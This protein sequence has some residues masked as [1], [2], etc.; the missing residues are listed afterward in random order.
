MVIPPNEIIVVGLCSAC[1]SRENPSVKGWPIIDSGSRSFRVETIQ[2][3][4]ICMEFVDVPEGQKHLCIRLSHS[5]WVE[6]QRVPRSSSGHH[7]P[8][9]CI[10]SFTVEVIPWVDN[11]PLGLGHFLAFSVENKPEAQT[12]LVGR[13]VKHSCRHGEQCVEPTTGLVDAFANVVNRE[14]FIECFTAIKWVMPLSKWSA[15]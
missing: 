9:S 7:V 4:V 1:Q 2:C 14:G 10:G 12:T 5:V 3:C 11:V 8:A 6:F 13:L 15:S